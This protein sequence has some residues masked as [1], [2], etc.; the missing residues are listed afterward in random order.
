MDL[1]RRAFE[2]NGEAGPSEKHENVSIEVG[3]AV[4]PP[5]FD[6]Q[7]T[8]MRSGDEKTFKV[9]YPADYAIAELQSKEVEYTVKVRA[10]RRRVVPPLDDDLAK[11]VSDA[12]TLEKLRE[13]VREGLEREAQREAD[14]KLRS[15]LL[16]RSPAR[17]PSR[18][19]RC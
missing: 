9:H 1:E 18:S 17:W 3:A 19:P 15:D 12:E 8:G 5:G 14:R 7:L 11:E 10:V 4:N 2:E 13:Q 16:R 6:E